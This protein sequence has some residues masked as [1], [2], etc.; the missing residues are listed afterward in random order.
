M[1]SKQLDSAL[2]ELVVDAAVGAAI[3][4]GVAPQPDE[5]GHEAVAEE[6]ARIVLSAPTPSNVALFG[7]WGSG[8]SGIGN[9]LGAKVRTAGVTFVSVD[10]FKHAD[11]PLRRDF[12]KEVAKP[13]PGAEKHIKNLHESIQKTDIKLDLADIGRMM[14]IFVLVFVVTALVCLGF[15]VAPGG[16]TWKQFYEYSLKVLPFVTAPGIVAAIIAA[17]I[18]KTLTFTRTA[19]APSEN[20]EFEKVFKDI[21][22]T[23]K[24]DRVVIFVD[25][26]DRCSAKEVNGT[27]EAIRTFLGVKNCVFVVAA[28]QHVLEIALREGSKQVTPENTIDPYY[29]SGSGF[30]DK[31]FGFQLHVPPTPSRRLTRYAEALVTNKGGLWGKVDRGLVISVLVPG[32][33]RSPRRVKA[34][35]N[36]FVIH[37]R[38]CAAKLPGVSLDSLAGRAPEIALWSVLR[39]EFPTFARECGQDPRLLRAAVELAKDSGWEAPAAFPQRLRDRAEQFLEGAAA[40]DELVV[41]ADANGDPASAPKEMVKRQGTQLRDF[42][43]RTQQVQT[44]RPDVIQLEEQGSA[45]GLEGTSASEI[46]EAAFNGKFQ[47][48]RDQVALLGE[49]ERRA[50]VQFLLQLLREA[51]IGLEAGNLAQSILEVVDAFPD[52]LTDPLSVQVALAIT[53]TSVDLNSNARRGALLVAGRAGSFGAGAVAAALPSVGDG[54]EAD[55]KLF[56]D[57]LLRCSAPELSTLATWVQATSWFLL[58]DPDAPTSLAQ[59][60]PERQTVVVQAL[61][62]QLAADLSYSP[63][64]DPGTTGSAATEAEAPVVDE[65]S[66]QRLMALVGETNLT[67]PARESLLLVALSVNQQAGSAAML[68]ALRTRPQTFSH[69][70]CAEVLHAVARFWPGDWP[71]LL[72]VLPAGYLSR[73]AADEL[74]D[75]LA[76]DALQG[77]LPSVDSLEPAIK[78]LLPL[79]E[80]AS[81]A[82]RVLAAVK[83]A[84]A[85]TAAEAKRRLTLAP[86]LTDVLQNTGGLTPTGASDFLV[87]LGTYALTTGLYQSADW[88]IGNIS[89]GRLRDATEATVAAFAA[90]VTAGPLDVDSTRLLELRCAHRLH[91]T[92]TPVQVTS[93]F[94]HV[95][96]LQTNPDVGP[97]MMT[98]WLDTQAR[99]DDVV[100]YFTAGHQPT[101]AIDEA[102][103]R[104]CARL[105]EADRHRLI[106]ELLELGPQAPTRGTLQSVTAPFSSRERVEL[107][108]ALHASSAIPDGS[109]LQAW[110]AVGSA[111]STRDHGELVRQVW[112]PMLATASGFKQAVEDIDRI[113]PAS[114]KVK[115]DAVSAVQARADEHQMRDFA[116]DRLSKA[117]YLKKRKKGPF[118]LGGSSYERTP[119]KGAGEGE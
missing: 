50:A 116:E 39:T 9:L 34:L 19:Q 18:G 25:E 30:L 49:D 37:Y 32:H 66:L 47:Q 36:A 76:E 61:R 98:L 28:D 45:F 92:S 70:G 58:H 95:L 56:G 59:L 79:V 51:A 74:V 62:N 77:Q 64:E 82:E 89:T 65:E 117:G 107:V 2:D 38:T 14:L 104:Y 54:G 17:T 60:D 10:A 75:Q 4:G 71:V 23:S 22:D 110:A 106:V 109:T 67:G 99:S 97:E 85:V 6:L 33:V 31:L 91:G 83:P 72:S 5:L 69:A 55:G 27:L 48:V 78:L 118:G 81:L 103:E 105:S 80:P 94:S 13:I 86:K 63:A 42:L 115:H 12:L 16:D 93:T 35:I 102:L 96:A 101:G 40:S 8:K 53:P 112:M 1:H 29:S 41:A 21:I 113:R 46:E 20:D 73:E 108:T 44:P 15:A 43:V 100:E 68:E 24:K 3:N 52:T 119:I 57:L 84:A 87:Q 114:A 7:P 90:A 88:Y 111:L 11:V 26:L